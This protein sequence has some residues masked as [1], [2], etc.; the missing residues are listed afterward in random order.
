MRSPVQCAFSHPTPP[1][2]AQADKLAI[3][4]HNYVC[5]IK[6]LQGKSS[7]SFSPSILCQILMNIKWWKNW[8]REMYAMVAL[9]MRARENKKFGVSCCTSP[10]LSQFTP[11]R[12]CLRWNDL[13]SMLGQSHISRIKIAKYAY[14]N[15]IIFGSLIIW[16]YCLFKRDS[17]T[18]ENFKMHHS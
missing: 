16:I 8:H 11:N 1:F 7:L 9:G 13:V 17:S 18:G 10:L 6:N 4:K 2:H 14:L 15:W 3:L 5:L 12:R